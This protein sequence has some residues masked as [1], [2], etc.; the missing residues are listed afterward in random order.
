[1]SD[2]LKIN[3]KSKKIKALVSDQI[4]NPEVFTEYSELAEKEKQEHVHEQELEE[5]FNKG[6][7]Q[8]RNIAKEELEKLYTKELQKQSEYFINVLSTFEEK[9]KKYENDFHRLVI[10]VSRKIAEKIIQSEISNFNNV[11]KILNENVN[12]ILGANEVTIIVN[13]IDHKMLLKNKNETLKNAGFTKIRFQVN[14]NIEPGGCLIETEIGN[15][16]ARI[17]SQL[18][19]IV[20]TLENKLTQNQIE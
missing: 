13:P 6:L 18:N 11:E 19:E 20:K 4:P 12:K 3:I 8:G 2:I 10:N 15:M 5:K 1:M 7:E 14:E 16:D 9:I 17:N